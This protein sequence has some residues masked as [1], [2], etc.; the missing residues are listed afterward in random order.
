MTKRYMRFEIWENM[1]GEL[2]NIGLAYIWQVK[3]VSNTNRLSMTM[4][5]GHNDLERQ[6]LF[7]KM[8]RNI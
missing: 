2:E 1:K 6:N 7:S 8:S 4:R 3:Q 5:E